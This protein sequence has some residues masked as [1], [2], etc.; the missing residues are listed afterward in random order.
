MPK[1]SLVKRELD[2]RKSE[3]DIYFEI[4]IKRLRNL[5]AYMKLGTLNEIYRKTQNFLS[6]LTFYISFLKETK[7]LEKYFTL[8]KIIICWVLRAICEFLKRFKM[9]NSC[10]LVNIQSKRFFEAFQR[11]DSVLISQHWSSLIFCDLRLKFLI[12]TFL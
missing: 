3:L 9:F 4:F 5:L 7:K 6:K 1:F 11:L 8:L 2:L 12:N 10:A